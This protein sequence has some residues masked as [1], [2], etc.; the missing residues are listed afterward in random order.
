MQPYDYKDIDTDI[1]YY[2][3]NSKL[4]D[5]VDRAKNWLLDSFNKKTVPAEETIYSLL[6][7]IESLE[8]RL[9][10]LERNDKV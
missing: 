3:V 10:E 1:N 6:R 8:R 2:D 5:E 9:D 4:F 7:R